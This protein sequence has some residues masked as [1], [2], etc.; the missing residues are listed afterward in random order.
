M[1]EII[2]TIEVEQRLGDES[3]QTRFLTTSVLPIFEAAGLLG[4]Q[5]SLG[6]GHVPRPVVRPQEHLG[7]GA[8]RRATAPCRAWLIEGQALRSVA[9][10]GA[11]GLGLTERCLSADSP[12]DDTKGDEGREL[13]K[14]RFDVERFQASFADAAEL[15]DERVEGGHGVGHVTKGAR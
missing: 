9:N 1:V 6:G 8:G 14:L 11:D 4:D 15:S 10:G 5:A 7:L 2:F 13:G 3:E 12:A